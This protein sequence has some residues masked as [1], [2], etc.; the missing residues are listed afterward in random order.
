T[1][2][3]SNADQFESETLLRQEAY[4][5]LSKEKNVQSVPA[6]G[7]PAP[8]EV[9]ISDNVVLIVFDSQWFL[10]PYDKPSIE[11]DC[12]CK[13]ENEFMLQLSELLRTNYNKLVVL[14]CH[15]PFISNSIHGGYV[16]LKQHIFR[17]TDMNKNL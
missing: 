1:H 2:A 3:S 12:D 4:V 8:V 9:P 6:E 16:G 10:H 5:N 11:W 13:T 15:H 7:C 14:C 17:F